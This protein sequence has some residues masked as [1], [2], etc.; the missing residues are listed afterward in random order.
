[1]GD[2]YTLGLFAGL[3][4]ALGV[5]VA[6]LLARVSAGAV[7]A[8]GLAAAGGFFIGWWFADWAEAI[9][10]GVGGALGAL[11]A[12]EVLRGALRRGG[13]PGATALLATAGAI[14]LG[15]LAFVPVAGYVEALAIPALAARLRR[16]GGR[17]YEGLRILA[18]D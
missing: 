17:T 10:G 2:W 5:L 11:G 3:G 18:R 4:A 15:A 12:A 1:M 8:L 13:T 6:G 14:L 16:R 7:A 9:A